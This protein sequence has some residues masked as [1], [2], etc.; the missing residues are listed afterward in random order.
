[1]ARQWIS[2]IL[3]VVF[4][5]A[6]LLAYNEFLKPESVKVSSE[7]KPRPVNVRQPELASVRDVINAVGTLR[8]RQQIEVVSEVSGRI[9]DLNFE[10]GERVEA[11]Q[12][13]VH[14]NDR[15]AKAD[16]QVAKAN[17]RDASRQYERGR[18]LRGKNSISQSSFDQLRT[19]FEV[20]EAQ[21]V[22]A[23]VVLDDHRIEAPFSGLAG[24]VDLSVGAYVDIGDIVTTLDAA[25]PVELNFSVPERFIG[26]ISPGTNLNAVTAAFPDRTFEGKLVQL[27]ARLDELSRTLPVRALIENTDGLLK[28]GLFM[29]VRLTLREREALVIPEQAVLVQG[30]RAYIF[31]VESSSK[32]RR[33]EVKLGSR[34]PG[35]VEV[36]SG[37][38]VSDQVVVTGQD[39]LSSGDLVSVFA[40][41]SAVLTTDREQ[42]D[43]VLEREST[44]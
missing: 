12:L 44:L 11:G 35:I 36:T 21:E 10:P 8:A 7:R 5:A 6:A 31:L 2:A 42:S 3:V 30:N 15:Q 41:D 37:L 13:L 28:P 25:G 32:V 39:R 20:A 43:I 18:S 38:E 26:A 16:M 34:E 27:G 22:A 1:M 29:S 9:I 23:S 24:L 4:A 33:Q 19:A 17:L 14:L 40:D